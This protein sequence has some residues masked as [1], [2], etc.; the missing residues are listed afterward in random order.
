MPRRARRPPVESGARCPSRALA[1]AALLAVALASGAC[2]VPRATPPDLLTADDS[3]LPNLRRGQEALRDRIAVEKEHVE[4]LN[5]ELAGLRSDEERLYETYLASEADYQLRAKDLAGVESDIAG[6]KTQLEAARVA[7]EAARQEQGTL[8][9]D[10]AA[11]QAAVA[12]L[13]R[14]VEAAHALRDAL[15]AQQAAESAGAAPMG[16]P[17]PESAGSSSAAPDSAAPGAAAPGPA[18]GPAPAEPA[19]GA[20]TD[21][22]P[23][24]PAAAPAPEPAPA[25]TPKAMARASA[26]TP[27]AIMRTRSAASPAT[28]RISLAEARDARGGGRDA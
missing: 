13:R 1:A 18:P 3:T 27:Q 21:G 11:T 8:Q 10:L 17:A 19:A 14:Q 20:P 25:E 9:A 23:V 16:P 12:D 15:A 22:R 7:L 6:V 26:E 24:P 2:G 28:A 4:A 5:Q